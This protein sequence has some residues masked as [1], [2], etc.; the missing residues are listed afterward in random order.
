[1]GRKIRNYL[2]NRRMQLRITFECLFITI[3]SSFLSGIVVYVTVWPV[4]KGYVPYALIHNAHDQIVF[5]LLCYGFPL[6]LFIAACCIVITHR[7]AGPLYNIEQKL[8][9]LIQGENVEIIT[10]RKDDELK[11]LAAKLNKLIL[12]LRSS[13]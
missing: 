10:L 6:I 2:I 7:I 4:V 8:D 11:E 9:K 5:R 13:K 3:L 1:M 12:M